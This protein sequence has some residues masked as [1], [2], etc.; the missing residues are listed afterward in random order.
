MEYI[1]VHCKFCYQSDVIRLY[2]ESLTENLN[3]YLC[4]V[5]F[6]FILYPLNQWSYS[7]S[8]MKSEKYSEQAIK[9]AFTLSHIQSTE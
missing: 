3:L 4:N 7:N 1:L 6:M 5:L 8:P 9:K 2:I